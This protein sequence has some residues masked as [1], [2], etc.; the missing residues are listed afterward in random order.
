MSDDKKVVAMPG[1]R[2]NQNPEVPQA[3]YDRFNAFSLELT[4]LIVRMSKDGMPAQLVIGML[5][6]EKADIL[7]SMLY[8]MTTDGEGD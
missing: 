8:S 3:F 7:E 1:C 5:E 6:C 4:D 2:V